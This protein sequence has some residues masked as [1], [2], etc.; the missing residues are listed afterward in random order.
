MEPTYNDVD[1]AAAMLVAR[2]SMPYFLGLFV[3]WTLHGASVVLVRPPPRAPSSLPLSLPPA[4]RPG[5]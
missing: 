4:A 2:R 1:L 5:D 3:S